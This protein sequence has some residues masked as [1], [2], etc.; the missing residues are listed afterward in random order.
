MRHHALNLALAA[1][2]ALGAQAEPALAR[3]GG[4]TVRAGIHNVD[5]KSDTGT[6]A[7]GTIRTTIDSDAAF[8]LGLG[9][10]FTENLAVDLSV[11][12]QRYEHTVSANGAA[13]LDIRHRPVILTGQW[14]F[15]TEGFSPFLA[16]GWHWTSV[17]GERPFG[18]LAGNR[19]S[20]G[21]GDGFVLG[22]GFD[23]HFSESLFLRVDAHYLDWKSNVA[24]GG[25]SVGRVK[26]NPW[27]LGLSLGLGF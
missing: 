25:A 1:A 2:L 6:L 14:H 17:G 20:V 26:V 15:G 11:A 10:F 4:F 22:G 3:E 19:V 24:V 13:A 9:Y 12:V 21:N 27:V 18:P 8:D 7:N 5:P 23:L 16:A